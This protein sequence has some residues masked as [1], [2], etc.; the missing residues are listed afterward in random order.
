LLIF[1]IARL[2]LVVLSS[3][4][5]S[6]PAMFAPLASVSDAAICVMLAIVALL[7]RIFPVPGSP[8]VSVDHA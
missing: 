8:V 5:A 1:T 3:H 2:L 4:V 7:P 6:M